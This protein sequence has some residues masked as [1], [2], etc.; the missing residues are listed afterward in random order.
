MFT[1][2]I[3]ERGKITR[4]M[5]GKVEKIDVQS[6]LENRIGDSVAVQGICLTITDTFKN[7]FS[8]E[9][10]EQ[11]VGRTTIRNWQVGDMVNLE[12]ALLPG[13]RIGGHFVL[14]HIDEVSRLI[15][16]KGNEYYF[17]SSVQNKK[18]LIPKGSIAIDGVSLTIGNV[19]KNI[20]SVFLIPETLK[21][22]TLS[23]LRVGSRVNIEYDYLAK[24]L[25]RG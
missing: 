12:R 16:I 1:G 10:I 13:S 23:N 15:R 14:G 22:T 2:I 5:R 11:T 21:S 7:G 3:E 9:T 18:Y 8:I 24:L 4:I 17:Q 20:F 25:V 19:S 6:T